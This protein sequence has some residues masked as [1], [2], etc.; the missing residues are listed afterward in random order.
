MLLPGLGSQFGFVI[1]GRGA[2]IRPMP[3]KPIELP[4]AVARA[5]VR[6]MHAC[7]AETDPIKRDAIAAEQ[8]T[9]LMVGTDGS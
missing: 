5:V 4:P 9:V 1:N 6:D 8:M 7:F 2:Y 3:R